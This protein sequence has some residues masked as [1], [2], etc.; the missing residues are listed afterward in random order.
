MGIAAL[1]TPCAR[2]PGGDDLLARDGLAGIADG[3]S[4]MPGPSSRSSI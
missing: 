1:D 3:A 4:S 2:F